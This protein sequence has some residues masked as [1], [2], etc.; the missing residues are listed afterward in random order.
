ML[1]VLHVPLHGLEG[2]DDGGVVAAG[3]FPPDLLHAHAGDFPQD[4]DG[5]APGRSH[6]GVALGAPNVGRGHV[7]GA[8]HLAND[9]FDGHRYRL[10][11]VEDILDGVL[12]HADHRLDALQHIIGVQLF[13]CALQLADVVFQVVG[14]ELCHVLGQVQMQQLCLALHDGNAGLKIRRLHIGGQTPLKAGA[15]TLLQALD[16][17]G[18]AI[19]GDDDLLVG[20]VQGVEGVEELFLRG[21]L[22]RDELD[23][24]HQQKVCHAV[25]HA[26]VL[27]AA[28]A[29]GG[30][31]LV[32]ELLTGDIHDDE[33]GVGALDLGLNGGQQMGLAKAGAAVDEQGVIGP[34]GVCRHS[35]RSSKRK[36]VGRPL[37]E[38][39][40]GELVVALRGGGVCLVLLGQHYFVG[41]G[42]GHH[43]GDVHIKA[44]HGLEGLF[45]QAKVPVGDDLAD[46]IVAHRQGDMAGVLKADGLQPVD[47]EIVRWLGHLRLAVHL[48]RF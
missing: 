42:A 18:G 40:E 9:L 20:V 21:L 3:E 11:L 14:N 4:I 7:E 32:G 45:E 33:I 39:F 38:V 8:G 29:D 44:Q 6:I 30:D 19:G 37:D 22:A 12:R 10:G 25:L 41:R 15:Q 36:L 47:I 5:N 46:K 24:V 2:V 48:G 23:I 31:Q 34:G 43:K 16:L 28:G 35:L 1:I 13:H 26:E 17:L 27:G